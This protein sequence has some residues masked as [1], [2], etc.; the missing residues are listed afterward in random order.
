MKLLLRKSVTLLHLWLSKSG[1]VTMNNSSFSRMRLEI[2]PVETKRVFFFAE[3]QV[4]PPSLY[5]GPVQAQAA[6]AERRRA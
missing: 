2:R 5:D 6:R 3:D 1:D 4:A